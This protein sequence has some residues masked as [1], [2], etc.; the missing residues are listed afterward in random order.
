MSKIANGGLTRSGTGCFIYKP[1]F[2]EVHG[3]NR[4]NT[5]RYA[6][7]KERTKEKTHTH[8]HT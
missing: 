4:L 7:Q 3:S 6:Q 1:L 5:D 8:V 2:T